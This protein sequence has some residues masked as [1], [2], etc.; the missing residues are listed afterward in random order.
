MNQEQNEGDDLK[1]LYE[2]RERAV[3]GDNRLTNS[4]NP[5][6]KIDG[7]LQMAGDMQESGSRLARPLVWW[8]SSMARLAMWKE[9]DIRI[10]V[11]LPSRHK[12]K[13]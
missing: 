3:W 5:N 11:R 12:K 10:T 7:Y 9:E 13:D 1:R 6:V 2:T 8:F 4:N